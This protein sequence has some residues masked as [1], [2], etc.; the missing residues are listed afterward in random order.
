[1]KS[2]AMVGLICG[3]ATLASG[4]CHN[5]CG[6]RMNPCYSSCSP[7]QGGF[8]PA[9][10]GCSSCGGDSSLISPMAPMTTPP[11]TS[12]AESGEFSAIGPTNNGYFPPASSTVMN[13]P[14]IYADQGSAIQPLPP[15][16]PYGAIPSSTT[17]LPVSTSPQFVPTSNFNTPIA[18]M[19]YQ[20]MG[21]QTFPAP[22]AQ[23]NGSCPTCQH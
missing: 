16:L 13:P 7:C 20:Q 17:T 23:L 19:S 6:M 9:P 2:F 8:S 10:E 18:P 12:E 11:M 21:F 22:A 3:F 14:S 1:M 15:P 5:P 4:C